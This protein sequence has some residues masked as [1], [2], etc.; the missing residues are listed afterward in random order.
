VTAYLAD[1][2]AAV[3]RAGERAGLENI[4][5][6]WRPHWDVAERY[7][8][9]YSAMANVADNLPPLSVPVASGDLLLVIDKKDGRV[10]VLRAGKVLA[11]AEV[12]VSDQAIELRYTL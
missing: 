6:E 4:H 12:R 7:L 11:P 9:R 2:F 8:R 5:G 1:A 10:R 3:A